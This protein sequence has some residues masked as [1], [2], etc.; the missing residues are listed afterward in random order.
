MHVLVQFV[1]LKKFKTAGYKP[2]PYLAAR[3][4][5]PQMCGTAVE[6]PITL[7]MSGTR[8]VTMSHSQSASQPVR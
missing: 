7:L 3:Q 6:Q 1:H 8:P 5:L 4:P 2:Q